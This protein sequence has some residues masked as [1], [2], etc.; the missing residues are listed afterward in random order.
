MPRMV[1]AS[2]EGAYSLMV[3]VRPVLLGRPGGRLDLPLEKGRY[4]KFREVAGLH[5]EEGGSAGID[6]ILIGHG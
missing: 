4:R 5:L 1:G 3:E 6:S 2:A